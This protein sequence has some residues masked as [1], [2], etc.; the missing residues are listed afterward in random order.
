MP[1][2]IIRASKPRAFYV[3]DD[4]YD[5]PI[6]PEVPTVDEHIATDTG[7]LDLHGNTI[8]RTPDPIGFGRRDG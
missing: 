5:E 1:R 7:L 2:Y 3:E 4:V 8:W 6:R